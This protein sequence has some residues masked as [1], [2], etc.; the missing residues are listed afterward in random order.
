[1]STAINPLPILPIIR[2]AI[3]IDAPCRYVLAN[4]WEIGVEPSKEALDEAEKAIVEACRQMG[5]IDGRMMF[6]VAARQLGDI[7]VTRLALHIA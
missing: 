4:G 1:M 7:A 5:P 3:V 2:G 6:T